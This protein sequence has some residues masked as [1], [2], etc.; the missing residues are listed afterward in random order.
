ML[1]WTAFHFWVFLD[2]QMF[3]LL[4]LFFFSLTG[5]GSCQA[6]SFESCCHPTC[7]PRGPQNCKCR[8][9]LGRDDSSASWAWTEPAAGWSV[10][11]EWVSSVGPAAVGDTLHSHG[12]PFSRCG[13]D[14]MASQL[15][16]LL[17]LHHA[18]VRASAGHCHFFQWQ[19]QLCFYPVVSW[20]CLLMLVWSS[21]PLSQAVLWWPRCGR[22]PHLRSKGAAPT[23]SQW[24]P[25]GKSVVGGERGGMRD[26][27]ETPGSCTLTSSL[28]GS[29]HLRPACETTRAHRRMLGKAINLAPEGLAL[30]L[31][32]VAQANPCP[33]SFSVF[34][35]SRYSPRSAPAQMFCVQRA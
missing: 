29:A 23:H 14:S 26:L 18:H 24:L 11:R 31:R 27:S 1:C 2:F 33:P 20:I 7:D 34:G 5:I 12:P 32:R 10:F 9:V 6:S 8:K 21:S 15:P 28:L 4:L 30:S 35:E 3:F 13:E 22:S 16:C 19:I 25:F 17:G